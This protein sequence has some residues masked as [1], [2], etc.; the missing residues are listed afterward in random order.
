MPPR[1]PLDAAVKYAPHGLPL[2]SGPLPPGAAE[3]DGP[4]APGA[5]APGVKV[6]WMT[7]LASTVGSTWPGSPWLRMQPAHSSNSWVGL[8]F[9]RV[10]VVLAPL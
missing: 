8:P 7:P 9:G 6:M 5:L 2:P 1:N 4:V 10:V 3:R